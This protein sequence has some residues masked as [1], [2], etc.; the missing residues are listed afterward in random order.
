MKNWFF[1]ALLA[2]SPLFFVAC[3]DSSAEAEV[4]EVSEGAT[5]TYAV[6]VANSVIKW[7]GSMLG[8]KFH[9][10]TLRIT[11]G[12]LVMENGVVVGGSF[13]ADMTSMSATDENYDAENPRENL[14]GHLASPDFFDVPSFPQ[15]TF[16]ISGGEGNSA[17]GT[18]TI[19]GTSN[20]ETVTGIV[21]AEE[22]NMVKA[23]GN[24]VFN[25]QKYGVA[26]DSGSKDFVLSD[27]IELM[28]EISAAK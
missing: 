1:L 4:T 25:R 28:L 2:F 20:E 24:L 11:E 22:G 10:G 16:V 26:W 5:G 15:A 9:E 14:I 3:G 23:T 18:M 7:K 13:T 6:D 12:S 21:V 8:I 17:M 19:R 27:D